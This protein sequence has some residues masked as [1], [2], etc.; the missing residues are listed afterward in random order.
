MRLQIGLGILLEQMILHHIHEIGGRA[1]FH[2][3]ADEPQFRFLRGSLLVR[4]DV[5]VLHHLS[6][7][8]VAGFHGAVHVTL[9]GGIAIG[10]AN[11]TGDKCRFAHS[12]FADVFAKV[13]L[14][15]FAEPADGKAAAV[16][17][18]NFVGVQLEDLLFREALIKLESH[19]HFFHFA[20]PLA[21]GGEEKTARHL[22]VDSAGALGFVT[23]AK[24]GQSGA[25]DANDVE[26]AMLEEAFVFGGE[27][28]VHEMAG[29]VVE[30]DYPAFLARTVEEIG[31]RLRLDLRG[32]A[33]QAVVELCDAGDGG[34]RE[35][36]SQGV[37]APEIGIGGRTNLYRRTCHAIFPRG[38]RHFALLIPARRRWLAKS[39]GRRDSPV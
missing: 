22:H 6:E 38:A 7:D 30:A 32:I 29:K 16:A 10:R 21:L 13:S 3:A 9:G 35:I 39:P 24:I 27:N 33:R 14:G 5:V 12:E 20:A 8:A 25:D 34:T 2:A 23:G 18:I 37:G 4:L 19:Q 31:D 11:N 26:A 1:A 36:N 17:E 28:S 15:S